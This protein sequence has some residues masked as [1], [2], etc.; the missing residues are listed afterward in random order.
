MLKGILPGDRYT[1]LSSV[2]G[3]WLL[4]GNRESDSLGLVKG[5]EFGVTGEGAWLCTLKVG[6][7]SPCVYK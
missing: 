1:C 7:S 6:W 5:L 4:S 2:G 3:T